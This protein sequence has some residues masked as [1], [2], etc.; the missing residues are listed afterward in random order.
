MGTSFSKAP[1]HLSS[2]DDTDV[3]LVPTSSPRRATPVTL[4]HGILTP[5]APKGVTSPL[6]R[7]LQTLPHLA[8]CPHRVAGMEVPQ[9]PMKEAGLPLMG[10]RPLQAPAAAI[11]QLKATK[12]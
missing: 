8:A 1:G 3:V 5:Q 2:L 4:N 9:L 6:R 7:T 10:C 11:G 12:G